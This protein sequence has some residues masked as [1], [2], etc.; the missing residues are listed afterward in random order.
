MNAARRAIDRAICDLARTPGSHAAR[1]TISTAD[2]AP[3]GRN[4][5]RPAE[6]SEVSG[7]DNKILIAMSFTMF[8]VY[9]DAVWL[10]LGSGLYTYLK[11]DAEDIK[12]AAFGA[13]AVGTWKRVRL[14]LGAD[15]ISLPD[16]DDY[17][18]HGSLALAFD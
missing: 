1:S 15:Q 8:P 16:A 10:G 9:G 6:D 13:R 7:A 17:Y 14:G 3:P 12:A 5:R 2:G 4:A 11:T 18:L